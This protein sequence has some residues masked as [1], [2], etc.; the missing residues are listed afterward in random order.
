[1]N[2]WMIVLLALTCVYIVLRA[3]AAVRAEPKSIN[4]E[5]PYLHSKKAYV[6]PE[7]MQEYAESMPKASGRKIGLY[8]KAWKR[9]IESILSFFGLIILSPLFLV[10]VIWIKIDDSGPVFFTQKRVGKDKTF[11]TLHKFRSMQMSTPHDIPT[12]MLENPD[13]YITKVGRFLR[14]SSLDELPQIWDIFRGKMSVIGPRPA[15]WNQA[16]LVAERERYGAND[17]MPGL[18]GWAQINGRDE[19]EIVDKARLDGEYVEMIS[20]GM[21]IR[22]FFGTIKSVMR[23]EGVV[24]GGTGELDRKEKEEAVRKL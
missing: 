17:V 4:D 19:L 15:L 1:M 13:Q 21:D 9:V 12:H 10:L 3:V 5:N 18:T 7:N 2:T 6:L 20:L 16:D 23:H 11:F 8:E 14:K 24:E 22:C